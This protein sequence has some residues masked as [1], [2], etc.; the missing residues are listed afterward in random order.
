[1]K[2][3]VTSGALAFALIAGPA[4]ADLLTFSCATEGDIGYN[5]MLND[6]DL[7]SVRLMISGGYDM[8]D[9]QRNQ[10]LARAAA[11]TGISFENPVYR[12]GTVDM[13]NGV[14]AF[15]DGPGNEFLACGLLRRDAASAQSAVGMPGRSLGGRLRAGPG[16]DFAQ[17]GSLA[18]NTPITIL[19]ATGVMMDGY[20]WF[21]VTS[22]R[23]TGYHWGGIMCATGGRA[24]VYASC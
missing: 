23:L 5:V 17:V 4:S 22:G 6:Q 2:T 20:E 15:L 3:I 24:G 8:T 21:E 9:A 7:S 19:N 12:F 18:E 11:G 1:M 10:V 13:V 16:L 14:L